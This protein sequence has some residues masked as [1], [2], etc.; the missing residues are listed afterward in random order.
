MQLAVPS[1]IAILI[2][3]LN[4]A[5]QGKSVAKTRKEHHVD[6]LSAINTSIR[7]PFF[8]LMLLEYHS[9]ACLTFHFPK[10][11]STFHNSP[12]QHDSVSSHNTFH[13]L[14]LPSP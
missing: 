9:I 4:K 10:L 1:K 11:S 14:A 8:H 6:G 7:R 5:H 3:P 12:P 2:L 13:P